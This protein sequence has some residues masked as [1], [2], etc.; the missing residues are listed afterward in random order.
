MLSLAAAV[1]TLSLHVPPMA[2][3]EAL[4]PRLQ[5]IA[6]HWDELSDSQRNRA[7][8]NYRQYNQLPADKKRNIDKHYEKWKKMPRSDQD[9]YR[10]KHDEYRSRGLVDD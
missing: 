9:R 3:A 8:R 2:R 6:E 5:Q 10:R 7:L 1:L 4:R